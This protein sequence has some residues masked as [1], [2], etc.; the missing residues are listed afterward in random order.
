MEMSELPFHI[1][2][3]RAKVLFPPV[4]IPVC[5]LGHTLND[6]DLEKTVYD[7]QPEGK[8]DRQNARV[9]KHL[10]VKTRDGNKFFG[11]IPE[12]ISAF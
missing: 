7:N 1:L 4:K 5:L 8:N 11:D 2:G 6:L 9:E 12:A 10:A 3:R